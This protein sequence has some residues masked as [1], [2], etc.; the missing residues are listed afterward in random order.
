LE[1]DKWRFMAEYDRLPE[2]VWDIWN[3]GSETIFQQILHEEMARGD[4][5]MDQLL[6]IL[7]HTLEGVL[8]VKE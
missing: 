3:S 7:P 1:I 8:N 2:I 4:W 5:Y 6:A